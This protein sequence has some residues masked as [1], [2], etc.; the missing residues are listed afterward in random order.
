[1]PGHSKHRREI[2][3]EAED[4]QE[5]GDLKVLSLRPVKESE[6]EKGSWPWIVERFIAAWTTGASVK[7]I[8]PC[9]YS[10]IVI[11]T[12]ILHYNSRKILRYLR[13]ISLCCTIFLVG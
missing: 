7:G 9:K 8:P 3:R 13:I 10:F 4:D 6:L 11:L 1:M 12:C 5:D 2:H